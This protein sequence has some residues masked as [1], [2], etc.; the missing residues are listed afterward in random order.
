MGRRRRH[1]RGS[2]GAA[3]SPDAAGRRAIADRV[4]IVDAMGDPRSAS[5]VGWTPGPGRTRPPPA[6]RLP[7]RT[8]ASGGQDG[9]P[10]R[11]ARG[12][13]L[14]GRRGN[15]P[16]GHGRRLPS[17]PRPRTGERRP[18]A[19]DRLDVA[20]ARLRDRIRTAVPDPDR[21]PAREAVFE[22]RAPAPGHAPPRRL[23]PAP[24]FRAAEGCRRSPAGRPP[25]PRDLCG[26]S[27]RMIAHPTALFMATHRAPYFRRPTRIRLVGAPRHGA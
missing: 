8:S 27:G 1:P 25:A 26:G 12:F 13:D 9:A 23:P 17:L 15:V 16:R 20:F 11:P 4:G 5:R 22:R 2:C 14:S 19:V 24:P 6:H 3:R 21:A 10:R 18:A 7:D